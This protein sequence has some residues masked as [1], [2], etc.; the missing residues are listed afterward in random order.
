MIY[1]ISDT[2]FYQDSIIKYCGRPFKNIKEMHEKIIENWNYTVKDSDTVYFLGDFSLGYQEQTRDILN[3]LNGI[4]LLI[5]GNHDINLTEEEWH[6]L[7][8]DTVFNTPQKL[9][10]V[11]NNQNFQYVI[12][13]HI[14][15]YIRDNEFNIHGHIHNDL[16][17]TQY[18][19]MNPKNHFCVSV[20]RI[21]YTP[22]SLTD[23]QKIIE[24]YKKEK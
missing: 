3:R 10:Y 2:H 8:F 21:N 13:S 23:I 5:M 7:G 12:L 20:E 6:S 22:I 9:Y 4:K 24:S 18:P 15:Q 16:L 11:D 14:P 19:D 17:E 1:F